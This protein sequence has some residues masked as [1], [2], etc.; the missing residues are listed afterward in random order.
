MTIT[1]V[2]SRKKI[3]AEAISSIISFNGKKIKAIYPAQPLGLWVVKYGSSMTPL[4]HED[5]TPIMGTYKKPSGRKGLYQVMFDI[6]TRKVVNELED[7]EKGMAILQSIEDVR[8]RPGDTSF[9]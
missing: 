5:L 4:F 6:V 8:K 7:R 9:W 1:F 3:E 2:Y